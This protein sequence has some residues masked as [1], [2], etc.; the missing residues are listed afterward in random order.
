MTGPERVWLPPVPPPSSLADSCRDVAAR[1]RLGPAG[2]E[3]DFYLTR[4]LWALGQVFQNELLLKG[5]TLL[6]K[7]DLGFF[8]LSEDMDL[9]IPGW[10][11]RLPVD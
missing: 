3:K 2:I 8:R 11:K 4:A 7:V 10:N 6:S 5:G 1:E 9:V